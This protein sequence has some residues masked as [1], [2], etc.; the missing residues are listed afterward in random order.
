MDVT[1]DFGGTLIFEKKGCSRNVKP[2]FENKCFRYTKRESLAF[3]DFRD[4][5]KVH[6]VLK[7][8]DV[9]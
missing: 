5:V 6:S 3:L 1:Q 4:T 7:D 9:H 2:S 8:R